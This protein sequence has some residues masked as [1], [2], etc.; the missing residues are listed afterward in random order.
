MQGA[1]YNGTLLL[2]IF[3]HISDENPP[4]QRFRNFNHSEALFG[5]VST[6]EPD[7]AKRARAATVDKPYLIL[8]F[9]LRNNATAS[10]R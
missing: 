10:F 4:K 6:F 1:Q 5:G 7:S 9:R 2:R 8:V 3:T